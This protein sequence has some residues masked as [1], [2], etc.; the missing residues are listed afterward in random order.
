M[1]RRSD[2][3][4]PP[5]EFPLGRVVLMRPLSFL[6]MAL[7]GAVA[8]LV[9]L[10]YL[11]VG[12]YTKRTH[13]TGLLA[14]DKASLTV[15]APVAGVVTQRQVHEGQVVKAGDLLFV[16]AARPE[17]VQ[18]PADTT[19]QLVEHARA[20][21]AESLQSRQAEVH[22]VDKQIV[23]QQHKLAQ[24]RAQV[25][26]L[27]QTIK[28]NQVS[29]PVMLQQLDDVLAQRSRL[30][31]LEKTRSRLA[32]D[33]SRL[34]GELAQ[35][36]VPKQQ[37]AAQP[38]APAPVLVKAPADGTVTAVMAEPGMTVDRHALLTM[39][40]ANTGVEAQLFLPS[41]QAALVQPGQKVQLRYR[42]APT[43]T[44]TR[45]EGTVIDVSLSPAAPQGQPQ[46]LAAGA[47]AAHRVRVSLSSQTVELH[48]QAQR[49]SAGMQV[50]A[51]ILQGSRRLLEW[52]FEPRISS[53]GRT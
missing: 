2:F 43:Q 45:L 10:V 15:T 13:A 29:D 7:F 36:A 51:E 46:P 20:R 16:L 41:R 12:D 4:N 9:L 42:M 34:Q 53:K 33:I 21:L 26:Q 11:S 31:V 37:Q 30:Q 8:A 28:E 35:A 49:L 24:S 40:P 19:L 39:T 1:P 25:V 22:K 52:A 50:E 18:K 5:S 47:D 3:A 27:R 17:S 6:V 38:E 48:G 23:A 44:F 32:Q 14:P